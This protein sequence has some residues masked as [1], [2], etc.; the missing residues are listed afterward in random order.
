MFFIRRFQRCHGDSNRFAF[1]ARRFWRI[2]TENQYIMEGVLITG[3]SGTIGMYLTSVLLS[4]GYNV[5]HLSRGHEQFGRVR[6]HRWDTGKGILDPKAFEGIG[7][8]VHLAGANIG[9]KRWDAARKKEILNSRVESARLVHKV[10][11]ENG[12]SLK[13]FIT[14]SG[15]SAYGTITTDRIFSETDPFS[16]DFLGNVCRKWEEAADLFAAS[17]IR[18]VKIRSALLLEKNDIA[19]KRMSQPARFGVLGYVGSGRQYMPWIH[20]ADIS[21]I[22]AMAIGNDAMTGAFNAVSPLHVT[23]KQFMET[24]SK[25]LGKPF[26]PVPAPPLALKAVY[27]EMADIVLK[28]S[29]VSSEKIRNAGFDF[30]FPDLNS[31]LRD[32]YAEDV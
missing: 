2:F 27:G 6:V 12:I 15:T 5:S 14:A 31:A 13:S 25:V 1:P 16:D 23:H 9:E 7:H 24:L 19:L 4:K 18:T 30:R 21:N 26:F 8:V 29:R 32:I 20:V 11:T 22:Y 28:G 10:V 3:G 17:G